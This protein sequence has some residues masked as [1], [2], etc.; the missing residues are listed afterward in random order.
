MSEPVTLRPPDSE[1]VQQAPK[2]P[3][4]E[5]ELFRPLEPGPT[6]PTESVEPVAEPVELR[7]PAPEPVANE[8]E[9]ELVVQPE[10]KPAPAAEATEP[11]PEPV[12]LRPHDPQL[13]RESVEPMAPE[14]EPTP[15][16]EDVGP[17]SET[18]AETSS[19]EEPAAT[20][21]DERDDLIESLRARVETQEVELGNLREQLEQERSR[22]DVEVHVRPEEE[23]P[24]AEPTGPVQAEQ[25]LLCV[26]TS[27]GYVLIDRVGVLP[28]V[29]QAVDVPEEEGRFTVTKV[30]RLP[31]NGRPCAYLQRA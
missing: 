1:P 16:V 26:P 29:G 20:M 15:P 2:V 21:R 12:E 13:A 4:P 6:A 22:K 3:S 31:R 5:A 18:V 17:V 28:S 30:V 14:P 11:L 9:P 7:R 23:Q 19:A 27:A 10:P 25:Y 8:P 24:P